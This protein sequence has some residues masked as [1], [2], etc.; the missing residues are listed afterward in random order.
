MHCQ[1]D[2]ILA[3]EIA[4][5]GRA[6]PK[7]DRALRDLIRLMSRENPLWGAPRDPELFMLVRR[8]SIDCFQ[9]PGTR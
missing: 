2:G 3:L 8:R 7:I 5:A 9:I 1:L 4:E 6:G